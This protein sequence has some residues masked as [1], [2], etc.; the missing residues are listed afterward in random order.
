MRSGGVETVEVREDAVE[1]YNDG[2]AEQIEGTVWNTGCSSWYLDDTGR[3]ATLWPDWTFRFR[4]R[5]KA[6]DV[7]DYV[8]ER[9]PAREPVAA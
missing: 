5:A 3:N 2:L 4:R 9:E 8:L 7:A 6:F 1:R